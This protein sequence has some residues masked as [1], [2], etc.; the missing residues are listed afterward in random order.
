MLA[1]SWLL[2]EAEE[3]NLHELGTSSLM[4]HAIDY[5]GLRQISTNDNM[6]RCYPVFEGC[7]GSAVRKYH[8][9]APWADEMESIYLCDE[10]VT[11]LGRMNR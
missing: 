9:G 8:L 2:D 1:P 5:Q 6:V 11:P 10:D 4:A 3:F 7:K